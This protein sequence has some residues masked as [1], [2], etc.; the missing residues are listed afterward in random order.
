MIIV[1][2]LMPLAAT[3]IQLA[4]SRSRE[5]LA[6]ETG[7]HACHDPLSLAS[8]LQKLHHN[9]KHAHLHKEDTV[10]AATASLFIISPFQDNPVSSFEKISELFSTHPPLHKRIEKLQ[11]MH[12]KELFKSF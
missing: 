6:D 10:H 8:A 12:E 3:I 4:L 9:S 11:N 2:I 1:A 7:A 5:Y